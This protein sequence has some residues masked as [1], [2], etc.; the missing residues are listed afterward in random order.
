MTQTQKMEFTPDFWGN[1]PFL[2]SGTSN[3]GSLNQLLSDWRF[4]AR[5][6]LVVKGWLSMYPL[7]EAGVQ[8]PKP[9]M[10]YLTKTTTRGNP[11]GNPQRLSFPASN[12]SQVKQLSFN[13]AQVML[14]IHQG[15]SLCTFPRD[16]RGHLLT[17]TKPASNPK[18]VV[19]S[20]LTQTK[21][22]SNPKLVVW[23]QVA[24]GFL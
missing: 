21:P 2:R 14:K 22:S 5:W 13:W 17:Q 3:R 9:T 20:L 16:H 19:W 23:S 24:W 1:D 10:S 12:I 4:G 6:G 15:D 7:Q 18:L 8:I 11:K